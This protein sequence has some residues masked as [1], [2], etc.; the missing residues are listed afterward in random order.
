MA[1]TGNEALVLGFENRDSVW[2]Y[3]L[4]TCSVTRPTARFALESPKDCHTIRRGARDVK[5][6]DENV[7]L[8]STGMGFMRVFD[9]R[10]ETR[11][12]GTISTGMS[13]ALLSGRGI[14]VYA[15]GCGCIAMYDRRMAESVKTSNGG[16]IKSFGGKGAI[17][18]N[19]EIARKVPEGERGLAYLGTPPGSAPGCVAYQ[20]ADGGVGLID[21]A[22][23]G[24]NV[25]IGEKEAAN[26]VSSMRRVLQEHGES[27]VFQ[28]RA[29]YLKRRQCDIVRTPGGRGWLITS[30]NVKRGGVRTVS[31]EPG[32]HAHSVD[33]VEHRDYSCV[34]TIRQSME[35]FVLGGPKNTVEVLDVNLIQSVQ[36]VNEEAI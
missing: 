1:P 26:T 36:P 33:I 25:Y 18:E 10:V 32:L 3:D 24:K 17:R 7:F 15:G 12:I 2:L 31:F 30:P 16:G 28:K 11:A 8:V 19:A 35:R 6:V 5:A 9:V 4:Q 14:Y 22:D 13:D 20:A 27:D 29:W 34:H 23:E 21:M